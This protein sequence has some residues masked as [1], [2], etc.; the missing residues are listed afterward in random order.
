[1]N[2][3]ERL[4]PSF[5]L[6][7][8]LA[9]DTAERDPALRAQQYDPPPD[10]VENLR[11]LATTALQPVRDL[12]GHPIRISSGYRCPAV[13]RLVKGSATSQHVLGQAA[14]CSLGAA[15]LDDPATRALREELASRFAAVAGKPLRGDVD[16][17]YLLF[18]AIVLELQRFDVDQVIHEYG[19]AYGRPAWVHIAAS[20][21][22]SGRQIIFV[23]R[24]TNGAYVKS[25]DARSA[26][27]RSGV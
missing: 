5:T 10:V 23:G 18:V 27:V 26:F 3:D 24:Y 6:R 20:T 12:L 19:E 7:E 4:S 25:S 1:M 2:L 8:L 11:Y 14:D 15:F 16:A 9:S 22:R 17:N 21:A 13:N